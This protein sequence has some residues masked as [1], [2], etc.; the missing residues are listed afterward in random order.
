MGIEPLGAIRLRHCL[1]CSVAEEYRRQSIAGGLRLLPGNA[2]ES[3]P[4]SETARED[5]QAHCRLGTRRRAGVSSRSDSFVRMAAVQAEW[6]TRTPGDGGG[7]VRNTL[8]RISRR[9]RDEED[10]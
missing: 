1:E 3:I 10:P 5:E 2:P 7:V 9:T 8:G 6:S 4:S